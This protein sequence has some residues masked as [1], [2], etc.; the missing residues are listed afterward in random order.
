MQ[1][2]NLDEAKARLRINDLWHLCGFPGKPEKSCRCP[3]HQDRHNS[4]SVFND[5]LNWKCFAGCGGGDAID[6][7]QRARD[8]TRPDACRE[9][10]RLVGGGG[11]AITH[12]SKRYGSKAQIAGREI[13]LDD[14]IPGD[15]KQW[16]TLAALR[17]VSV[18]SIAIA[19][20]RGLLVFGTFHGHAAW[21][22]TD[23]AHRNAQ[24]RRMDGSPWV[25][26]EGKKKKALTLAG[27][28]AAWPIGA[29]ESRRYPCLAFCE[30]GG[31]MLAALHFIWCE[32]RELDCAAVGML[33]A[34]LNIHLN[35][36][37]L[38]AGKHIRISATLSR[39]AQVVRR[40]NA[41]LASSRAPERTWTPSTSLT[42]AKATARS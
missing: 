32:D 36:L 2:S 39:A 25:D 7:L 40:L 5:G 1:K 8:L 3:F 29:A 30:G 41:G 11:M 38:F 26:L 21:F 23:S 22:I 12:G 6:F 19:V 42:F 16:R 24:A 15:R 28:Q 10:I 34:G 33:G 35:A 31:D 4:F 17:N 37:A 13:R 9:F 27:S 14:A 20:K 18:E